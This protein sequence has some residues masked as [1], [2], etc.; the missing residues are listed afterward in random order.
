MGRR[1]GEWEDAGRGLPKAADMAQVE[2]LIRESTHVGQPPDSPVRGTL[3]ADGVRESVLGLP[4]EPAVLVPAL[5]G[6]AAGPVGTSGAADR[7]LVSKA[8]SRDL[9]VVQKADDRIRRR[10]ERIV[11]AALRAPELP[12]DGSAPAGWSKRDV[13]VARDATST[14]KTAPAYL[15]MAQRV[16]ESYRKLDA[17][18][19]PSPPLNAIQI[20]VNNPTF[21]Y[22]VVKVER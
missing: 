20:V 18:K 22:P 12:E 13:R 19:E 9:A 10:A 8:L 17:A 14:L 11:A 15:G 6:S 16:L 1:G 21:S 3:V 5:P 2:P 7:G 4:G